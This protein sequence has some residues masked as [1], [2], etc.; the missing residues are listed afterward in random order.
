MPDHAPEAFEA[1][2]NAYPRKDDRKAAIRAWDKLKPD[3][4]LC[5]VMYRALKRQCASEQWA[6][7]GGKYIP[8]FPT[9]LN[10]RKWEN[11]GVDLSLLTGPRDSGGYWADA[12]GSAD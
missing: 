10:G 5:Q 4:E 3:R 7:A 8:M 12:P 11:Q 6:E 9:W 1:F 2:W